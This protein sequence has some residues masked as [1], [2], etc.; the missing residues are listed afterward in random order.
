MQQ[1]E[2]KAQY[3]IK[4]RE[5]VVNLLLIAQNLEGLET[6][7]K[8]LSTKI[9]Y[10]G[11]EYEFHFAQEIKGSKIPVQCTISQLKEI[12]DVKIEY[13]F[14]NEKLIIEIN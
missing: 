12:F 4:R 14:P 8:D 11:R 9:Y 2:N 5:Y 1:V 13:D 3:D 7:G 10:K 6:S